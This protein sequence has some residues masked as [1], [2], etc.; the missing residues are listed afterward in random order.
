MGV[1]AT[2]KNKGVSIKIMAIELPRYYTLFFKPS[3]ADNSV[4][5][6]GIW[7]KF[8]LTKTFMHV[9]VT[10]KIVEDPIARVATTIFSL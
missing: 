10:G 9:L 8:E 6:R 5:S 1:L 3:M 2:W 7:S 4:A